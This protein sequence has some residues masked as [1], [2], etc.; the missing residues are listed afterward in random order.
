MINTFTARKLTVKHLGELIEGGQHIAAIIQTANN[1]TVHMEGTV[2][3]IKYMHTPDS[4][5]V[6]SKPDDSAFPA[7]FARRCRTGEQKTTQN[8]QYAK[9]LFHDVPSPVLL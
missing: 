3:A 8:R 4:L 1:I 9:M 7:W 2:G 5:S 6:R